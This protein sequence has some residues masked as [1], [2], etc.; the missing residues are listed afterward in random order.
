MLA[1]WIDAGWLYMDRWDDQYTMEVFTFSVSFFLGPFLGGRKQIGHEE[2][3]RNSNGWEK[4]RKS[5]AR[6][7]N[8]CKSDLR[9]TR[10]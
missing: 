10:K 3:R 5:E 2:Q 4:H 8:G 7:S 6:K 1:S 9:V